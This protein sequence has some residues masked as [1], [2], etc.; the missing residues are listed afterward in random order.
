MIRCLIIIVVGLLIGS[1]KPT[2]S[3]STSST[4]GGKHHEDLSAYRPETT[5]PVEKKTDTHQ[6]N[7]PRE[8]NHQEPLYT[9]NKQLEAV[10]DSID[11]VNLTRKFVDGYTIQVY[12]GL[13]KE[14]AINAR[15]DLL[16]YLPGIESEVQYT[17]PNFRVRA[18]KYFSLLDAQKDIT[19]IRQYFPA[20]IVIPDRIPIN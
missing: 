17:Q 16:T 9:V 6:N 7:T 19:T 11:R 4:T 13:R 15:R 2:S 8:Q 10:L 20:A 1:C 18:G 12:S 3:T 14:D 5:D